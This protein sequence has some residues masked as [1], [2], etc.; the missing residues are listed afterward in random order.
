MVLGPAAYLTQAVL[1]IEAASRGVN[2]LQHLF[3]FTTT[4]GAYL[5]NLSTA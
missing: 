2:P 3:A 4:V 5:D 1:M